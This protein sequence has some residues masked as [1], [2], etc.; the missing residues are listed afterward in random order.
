MLRTNTLAVAVAVLSGTGPAWGNAVLEQAAA[1]RARGDTDAELSLLKEAISREPSNG[2]LVVALAQA[3]QRSNN[4]SWAMR[5]LSRYLE[6]QGPACPVTLALAY[7][8]LTRAELSEARQLLDQ[9]GCT[10]PPEVFARRKLLSA[11]ISVLEE[12][13]ERARA[14]LDEVRQ[15]PRIF[16][17]DEALLAHLTRATTPERLPR[18]NGAVNLE[19]GWTSQGLAGSPVDQTTRENS[20]TAI[21]VL[22]ARL[23]VMPKQTGNLRPLV[24]GHVQANQLWSDQASELSFRTGTGRVGVLL[25]RELPRVK[26]LGAFDVTQTEGGDQYEDGPEWYAEGASCRART[27]ALQPSLRDGWRWAP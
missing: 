21:T 9:S 19:A 2:E 18:V 1:L 12:R 24:E 6:E 7:L 11:Y 3:Y 10:V 22:G 17:E 8:K 4:S 23:E 26:V 27:H 5:T 20:G 25:G 14:L 15:S 13:L 16:E